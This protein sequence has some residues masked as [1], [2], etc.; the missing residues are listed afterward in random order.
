M[1]WEPAEGS[2]LR[3]HVASTAREVDDL[4]GRVQTRNERV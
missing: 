3:C 1:H 2:E 4:G